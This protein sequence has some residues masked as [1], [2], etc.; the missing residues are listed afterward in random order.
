M[1]LKFI[2]YVP[3]THL[4][5]VKQAIF[6][7]GAG[8]AQNYDRCCWQTLGTGQFRPLSGSNPFI[9]QQN[10]ITKV[11]EYKVETICSAINIAKVIQAL[12]D[13]HPY[14]EP[15]FE[16]YHIEYS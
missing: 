5:L 16:A 7:A 1:F 2:F 13:S 8:K 6:A 3:E 15:V 12:K 4:E 9:G 11:A 14:E 10:E